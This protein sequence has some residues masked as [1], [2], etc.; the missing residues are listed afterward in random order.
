MNQINKLCFQKKIKTDK[1]MIT[2][3]IDKKKK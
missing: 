2:N 1:T 3:I